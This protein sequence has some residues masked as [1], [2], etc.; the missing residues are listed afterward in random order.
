[1][2]AFFELLFGYLAIRMTIFVFGVLSGSIFGIIY[3]A[4]N[5]VDFIYEN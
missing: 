5:Y 3:T 1:M 2:M 4:E